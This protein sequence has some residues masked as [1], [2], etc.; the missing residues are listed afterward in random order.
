MEAAATSFSSASAE[1]IA[2]ARE[3]GGSA[4][5]RLADTNDIKDVKTSS[6]YNEFFDVLMT[7]KR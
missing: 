1:V 5:N 4:R 6:S 2:T 3:G 7:V